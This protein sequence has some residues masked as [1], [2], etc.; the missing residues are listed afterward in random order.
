MTPTDKGHILMLC[1]AL[2]D[3]AEKTHEHYTRLQIDI[4]QAKLELLIEKTISKK[5]NQEIQIK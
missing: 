4:V 1:G 3:I 5:L 2:N